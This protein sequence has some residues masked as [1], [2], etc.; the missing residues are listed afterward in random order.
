MFVSVWDFGEYSFSSNA[1]FD[2]EKNI[3]FDIETID[4]ENIELNHLGRVYVEFSDGE[5]YEIEELEKQNGEKIFKLK[6]Y[7]VVI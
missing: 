4:T 1:K 3:V 6:N 7:D 2:K 5:I